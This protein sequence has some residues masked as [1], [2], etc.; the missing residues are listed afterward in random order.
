LYTQAKGRSVFTAGY[1]LHR[2]VPSRADPHKFRSALQATHALRP[3]AAPPQARQ[4]LHPQ[5]QHSVVEHALDRSIE[6]LLPLARHLPSLVPV[7]QALAPMRRACGK[8]LARGLQPC[9]QALTPALQERQSDALAAHDALV[10]EALMA[11][12]H[13]K[14]GDWGD[15]LVDL[16]NLVAH[17][18]SELS[19]SPSVPMAERLHVIDTLHRFN[20]CAGSY[21]AWIEHL[22]PMVRAGA[23][24]GRPVHILELASGTGGFALAL[25]RYFGAAVRVTA[26]D[27]EGDYLALGERE[28]A[29]SGCDVQFAV[30]DATHLENLDGPPVDLIVCTQSL[31]HFAPGALSRMLG[32]AA[33]A[34][35]LGVCFIDAERGVLPL[36]LMTGVMALYGRRWPV[37]HDTAV[38]IRRMYVC[39]ELELLSRLAP[40]L[41]SACRIRAARMPPGHVHVTLQRPST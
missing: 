36:A 21:A 13:N 12:R 30:Q 15:A 18:G 31:H 35:K 8:A 24:G 41:P 3:A 16:D 40:G 10:Q 2:V 34:A 4:G 19:D 32:Q 33:N 22:E 17:G 7:S 6:S 5:A 11:L 39:E 37:V 38:S 25:K 26:T 20:T 29:R 28:A 23:S 27:M 1:A 14:R 9:V